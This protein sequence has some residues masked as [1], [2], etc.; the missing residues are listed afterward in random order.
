MTT[1][2][3]A[4][5]RALY[6][7]FSRTINETTLKRAVLLYDE[8]LFVD[9][10][11]HRVRAGLYGVEEHLPYL[12]ANVATSL[13]QEWTAI[14]NRY[15][16]LLRE[17][18]LRL[19]DPARVVTEPANDRLIARALRADLAD[20]QARGLFERGYPTTWSMLR[21]RIP[22]QAFA[23]LAHQIPARVLGR[24][25][26]SGLVAFYL[27]GHP[28]A[29][30][31][32]AGT[33][34][35]DD[36]HDYAALVPYI[37]G[38]SLATSTALALA[39][40][41]DAVPLTD[42]SAHFRLLSMRMAR[43]AAAASEVQRIPGLQAEPDPVRA[44]KTALVQQRVVDSVISH[45]D[46]AALSLED[47]LRYRERTHEER[48]AFRS[49]L[50]DVVRT[51]HAEPW[52]PE[53]VSQIEE[54][55]AAARQEIHDHAQSLR[56]AYR[57]LFHRTLAG[58]SVTAAPALLTTVFPVVSPLTIVLFGGGPLTAVLQEPVRELLTHWLKRDRGASSLAYLMD[59]PKPR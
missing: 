41:E 42:S 33:V 3:P 48:Q 15:D 51:A 54:R 57:S 22:Q 38:S 13:A 5:F 56:E 27:D 32:D 53:I 37:A 30:P 17:G 55:I 29:H 39:L 36:G 45:Q 1:A 52:S 19:I 58:L 40:A 18:L 8:I 34:W 28:Q 44:Q 11:S 49:F 20:P 26:V 14:S 2:Q 7:P 24:A 10:M 21:T 23:H 6:Y 46:L 12:P 47:C 4:A 59:L 35:P 31:S 9:P 16:L 43:A 50:H 25:N